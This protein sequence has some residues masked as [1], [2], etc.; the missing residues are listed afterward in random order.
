[1]WNLPLSPSACTC[2]RLG[3]PSMGK[4]WEAAAAPVPCSLGDRSSGT[5]APHPPLTPGT[6]VWGKDG[7]QRTVA[8]LL[9]SWSQEG[10]GNI[11][12]LLD[13]FQPLGRQGKHFTTT[14]LLLV[15]W[16]TQAAGKCTDIY[17][18]R[19]NSPRSDIYW[20]EDGLFFSQ[21]YHFCSG[22]KSVNDFMLMVYTMRAMIL[23]VETKC[24][25]VA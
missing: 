17:P 1:M 4:V 5:K 7:K 3:D 25:Y 14:K 9:G 16:R 6:P 15:P 18:A 10:M 20:T 22:R 23:L 13:F 11:F 24:L 21:N 12:P 2:Q 8:P 19:R